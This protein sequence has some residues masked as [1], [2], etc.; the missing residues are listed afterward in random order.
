MGVVR[1]HVG[2][3]PER[4]AYGCANTAISTRQVNDKH[5]GYQQQ[6]AGEGERCSDQ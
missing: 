3:V 6:Q 5:L 2:V 1:E 4:G